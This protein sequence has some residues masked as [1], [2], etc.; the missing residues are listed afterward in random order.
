M[1]QE[2]IQLLLN[3]GRDQ[4]SIGL[5]PGGDPF[6]I[7][8][9]G[10][11]KSLATLFPPRRIKQ[12]VTLIDAGSFV[13]YVNRFK[14][15]DTLI[16]AQV[17]ETAATFTAVLD[18]HK[19][20]EA[21]P[22]Y[23]QHRATFTTLPTPEWSAW[24][25]AN[26]TPMDQVTFA[27]WLEDNLNLFVVPNDASGKPLPDV[28]SGA[29]LLELV[30]TLHGHQNARFTT[31]LRLNTG[32]YSVNY[33]EDIVVQG[34][35][36]SKPGALELPKQIVGGFAIFQGGDNFAVPARLKTRISERKLM[37]HYETINVPQLIRD[38]LIG[39]EQHPGIVRQIASKT[40]ILPFLGTPQ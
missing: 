9:G 23:C 38:N 36:T 24:L 27:T 32:A 35:S 5:N 8:P 18:Y 37:L 16:F 26:R 4:N 12:T 3:T 31:A 15:P 20:T 2:A 29:D 6:F 19:P 21:K 1:T 25:K 7:T 10:E 34:S 30:Q 22:D 40:G 11:A 17:S 39:D 13:D 33:D 28:P 14:S